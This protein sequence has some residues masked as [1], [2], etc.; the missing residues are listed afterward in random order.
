MRERLTGTLL[1]CDQ[2]YE[3][4]GKLSILGVP[5]NV[6]AP[7][8]RRLSVVAVI[9]VTDPTAGG[10]VELTL[11][12]RRGDQ[13]GKPLL[14]GTI[15]GEPSSDV[16][17]HHEPHQQVIAPLYLPVVDLEPSATYLLELLYEGE[18]LSSATFRTR[19]SDDTEQIEEAADTL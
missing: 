5:W 10:S 15:Q 19:G 14:E 6:T 1:L 16:D 4:R 11:R 3:D 18:Q 7:G 12:L 2:L 9:T 8:K 17:D 13:E